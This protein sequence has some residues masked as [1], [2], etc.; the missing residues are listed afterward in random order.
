M[1][2]RKTKKPLGRKKVAATE[3]K[4]NTQKV[5]GARGKHEHTGFGDSGE[6]GSGGVQECN[7]VKVPGGPRR[8]TITRGGNDP[9]QTHN[10]GVKVC[11]R[12]KTR[13]S[14]DPQRGASPRAATAPHKA[15]IKIQCPAGEIVTSS[16]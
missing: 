3:D 6:N 2:G 5:R 13:C 16:R 9:P 14:A 7:T 1:P 4:K 15:G 10:Q 11:K 12:N 8:G